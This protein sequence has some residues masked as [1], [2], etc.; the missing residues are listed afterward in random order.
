[1][2]LEVGSTNSDSRVVANYFVGCVRQLGDTATVVR[3]DYGT[4]NVK[5][6]G[7]QKA[8]A[9]CMASLPRIRGLKPGGVSYEEIVQSGGLITSM[10]WEISACIVMVMSCM[11]NA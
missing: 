3:A 8:K 11:W 1:M 2:W 4:E 7:I 9:S 6:T 10:I 5:V